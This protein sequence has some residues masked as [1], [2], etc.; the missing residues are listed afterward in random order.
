MILSSILG[1]SWKLHTYIS[2]IPEQPVSKS[3]AAADF[4]GQLA[5]PDF[6]HEN[7][8]E[9]CGKKGTEY[10]VV[11]HVPFSGLGLL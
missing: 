10:F 7:L 2:K 1:T 11:G 9:T 6:F 5:T 3:R 8:G 4:L